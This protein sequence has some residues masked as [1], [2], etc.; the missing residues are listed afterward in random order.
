MLMLFLL[1]YCVNM[2]NITLQDFYCQN[3]LTLLLNLASFIC[4]CICFYVDIKVNIICRWH[5]TVGHYGIEEILAGITAFY[6]SM[7]AK[8]KYYPLLS[9]LRVSLSAGPRVM[10]SHLSSLLSSVVI[11]VCLILS[12][13]SV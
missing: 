9:E 7:I 5:V 4:Q 8:R 10:T 12:S 13:L 11:D 2:R 6:K 1:Y 3:V